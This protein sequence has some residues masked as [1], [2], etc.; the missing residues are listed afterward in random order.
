[1]NTLDQP[2][3]S[4]AIGG[5]A[6]PSLGAKLGQPGTIPPSSVDGQTT[7]ELPRVHPIDMI[8]REITMPDGI[9]AETAERKLVDQ[10]GDGIGFKFG[11]SEVD[12][13]QVKTWWDGLPPVGKQA[14]QAGTAT[15]A[16]TAGASR[17]GGAD[18]NQRLSEARA[19]SLSQYLSENYKI[20]AT[21]ITQIPIGEEGARGVGSPDGVDD[22][23]DRVAHIEIFA[24]APVEQNELRTQTDG[25]LGF[26]PVLPPGPNHFSPTDC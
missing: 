14:L 22:K 17:P 21:S 20:P 8:H 1:M 19:A 5:G 13:G 24:D 16:I 15:I 23:A 25:K 18:L 26:T 3:Q 11:S 12:P 9:A 6:S 7:T 2:S 4:A 10:P